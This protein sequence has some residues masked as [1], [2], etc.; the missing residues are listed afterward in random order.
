MRS[1]PLLR[2]NRF[3]RGGAAVLAMLFLVLMTTLSVAMFS[4]T[5]LNVQTAANLSDLDRARA[6][7]ESG[8]RWQE[9]RL[10]QLRPR[11]SVGSLTASDANALWS[12]LRTALINDFNSLPWPGAGTLTTG[13]NFVQTSGMPLDSE[14]AAFALRIEKL[15]GYS[16]DPDDE[17]YRHFIRVTSTGIVNA[18]SSRETRRSLSLTYTLDKKVRFAVIGRVPIQLGRN[19]IVEGPVAMATA[20]KYPPLLVLS[21]FRHL[22]PA[23]TARVEA[24]D[25]FLKAR[26][27]NWD[28][29]IS[30]TE[31]GDYAAA[32]AAGYEDVNGDY[33]IDEY[34]LFLDFFDSDNDGAIT[35]VEFTNPTTGKLYDSELF[36]AIDSLGGP[37]YAGDTPRS[38][39]N[40]GRID[41]DDLYAKISGQVRLATTSNAWSSN[42]ASSGKTIDDMINGPIAATEAGQAPVRFGASSSDFI[43]LLPSNFNT[44]SFKARTGSAAGPTSKTATVIA[45]TTVTAADA[46]G[47]TVVERTPYGSTSWQATYRRPV[48]RNMTFRNC[49]F[50]RGL[51]ALFEN[52]TFEGVTFV[53]LETNITTSSGATTT[54]PNDGMNW[55]KRMIS[56]SF[57]NNTTLTSTN[58]HGF[59]RGNNFR[60]NDCTFRGP[61]AS[62]VPTA[63]THFTN[64]WEFT[65]ATRFDNQVD[66]TATIVAPQTNIEMGSFTNPELAPSTLVGVV[67]AGNIDIRGT[68]VVDGSIIV[69]GDGAGNTTLGWFGPSDSS[70]DATAMPEG[71]FGRL[72]IRY[73]PHRALP[74]G[75]DTK[76]EIR[77][78][79]ATFTEA[80]HQ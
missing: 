65:G 17:N 31:S 73:N 49:R 27:G 9:L 69:T 41:N 43:D 29:R 39:F 16:T 25:A 79:L 1:R 59:N 76:V 7:A 4:A 28:N 18:G 30:I 11:S 46:N 21:D 58:S 80:V 67:V 45:N 75:I 5:T 52:C 68:S 40:D 60:F 54:N 56:G 71:G 51:N 37:Q 62:D 77:P 66:A 47:G 22:T 19:T 8:L 63:Y 78:V 35:R 33:Y 12:Q 32:L 20:N 2:S 23:L 42:L 14:G 72:N 3:R 70:T 13:A 6:A 26:P 15:P 50:P 53:E 38:G 34:D 36:A 57:S 10:D 24:F 74:D 55:S 64:S 61:L 44:S 48:F